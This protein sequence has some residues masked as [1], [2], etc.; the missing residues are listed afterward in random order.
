[1]SD[2]SPTS[3]YA[4][5]KA[6]LTPRALYP[7]SKFVNYWTIWMRVVYLF[8]IIAFPLFMGWSELF[9]SV[10][11][12]FISA[13]CDFFSFVNMYISAHKIQYDKYGKPIT[14]LAILRRQYLID[15]RGY[16][17]LLL[18]IPWELFVFCIAEL[19]MRL[20]SGRELDF[21]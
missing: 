14:N 12:L 7:D 1:M 5:I 18:S 21:V 20:A 8:N 10:G 4:R 3:I 17:V 16:T 9:Q 13:L 19:H 2:E 15:K 6:F 11:V